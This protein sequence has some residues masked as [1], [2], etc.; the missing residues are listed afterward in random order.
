MRHRLPPICLLTALALAHSLV[1]SQVI[2][3]G[4]ARQR[5]QVAAAPDEG[6]WPCFNGPRG[7][8]RAPDT[9]LLKQWPADG[10][11]LI[12]RFGDCGVGF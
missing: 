6:S 4:P 8:N 5:G 12:W 11:S 3:D 1:S 2:A 9:G 10:P 7:D